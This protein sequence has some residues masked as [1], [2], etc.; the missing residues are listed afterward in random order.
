MVAGSVPHAYLIVKLM[1]ILPAH[2]CSSFSSASLSVPTGGALDTSN[3][4]M[5]AGTKGS[6][7]GAETQVVS[8]DC[9][10]GT[11]V[12]RQISQNQFAQGKYCGS[13]C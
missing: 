5:M 2:L 13:I 7:S 10:H 11:S 1:V 3:R 9:Y 8:S 4:T 6:T 12:C